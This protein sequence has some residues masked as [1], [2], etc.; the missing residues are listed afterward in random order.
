[1]KRLSI[2]LFLPFLSFLIFS[3]C[4]ED[5]QPLKTEIEILKAEKNK[6]NND[7]DNLNA[8]FREEEEN[9][10]EAEEGI[11]AIFRDIG[12]QIVK[13]SIIVSPRAFKSFSFSM[14]DRIMKNVFAQVEFVAKGGGNDISVYVMDDINFINWSNGQQAKVLYS[15]DRITSDRFKV[16]ITKSGDYYLVLDNTF[17]LLTSKT[18]DVSARITFELR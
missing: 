10:I 3:G 11:K 15:A 14:D 8:K 4:G 5:A 18:V 7:I 9:R 6:L 12:I 16:P 2:I 13:G 1:M 17:S